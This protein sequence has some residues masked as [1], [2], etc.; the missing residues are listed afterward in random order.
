PHRPVVEVRLVAE[1][2]R[3]VPRL[4]LVRTSEEADDLVVLGVGGH[5]VPGARGEAGRHVLH[6]GVHLLGLVAIRLRHLGD[7][8]EDVGLAVLARALP[9]TGRLPHRGPFLGRERLGR[10]GLRRLGG[11][12]LSHR[13]TSVCRDES[14]RYSAVGRKSRASRAIR[15][16]AASWTSERSCAHGCS[17]VR[18][19]MSRHHAA[20]PPYS[21]LRAARSNAWPIR[22]RS[23]AAISFTTP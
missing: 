17:V 9:L 11:L 23:S 8:G 1:A 19:A 7:L 10:L 2:E 5:P 15:A 16:K 22:R 4:E 14:G 12:P 18:W 13:D 6:D 21:S 3:R 20:A